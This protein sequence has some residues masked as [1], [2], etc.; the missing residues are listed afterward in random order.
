MVL[1]LLP[2]TTGSANC[3]FA[4]MFGCHSSILKGVWAM[5]YQIAA[6]RAVKGGFGTPR[7]YIQFNSV[8]LVCAEYQPRRLIWLLLHLSTSEQ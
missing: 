4:I 1:P 2:L 7:S 8:C 5:I 3:G 6:Q